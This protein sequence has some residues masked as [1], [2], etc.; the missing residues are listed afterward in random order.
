MTSSQ[1]SCKPVQFAARPKGTPHEWSNRVGDVI[2]CWD[3]PN[4]VLDMLDAIRDNK[5]QVFSPNH[6]ES[7][8]LRT[9][10]LFRDPKECTVASSDM[11]RQSSGRVNTYPHPAV[12][13]PSTEASSGKLT[14]AFLGTF[15]KGNIT[16]PSAAHFSTG[17]YPTI[18][19]DHCLTHVTM[20]T[21]WE[22]APGFILSRPYIDPEEVGHSWRRDGFDD[23]EAGYKIPLE[24]L[25][26]LGEFHEEQF[27]KWK[28][29]A[30][31]RRLGTSVSR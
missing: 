12:I 29:E 30:N 15:G 17:I 25:D 7:V 21:G 3:S 26:K 10:A 19:P 18:A 23:T 2:T 20:A 31:R 22:V 6:H 4:I 27:R 14:I 9:D 5:S 16:R 1:Y 28:I 24:Q 11:T 13:L 8:K